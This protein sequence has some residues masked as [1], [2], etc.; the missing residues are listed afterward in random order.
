[1][2]APT[3]P[4]LPFLLGSNPVP[5]VDPADL[6]RMWERQE[7]FRVDSPD[8]HGAVVDMSGACSAGADLPAVGFRLS[9]L[10]LM[11]RIK[12]FPPGT[13]LPDALFRVL[14]TIPMTGMAPG[15]PQ[16]KLPFDPDELI[17]LLKE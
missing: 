15:A 10:S 4:R 5:A 7:E 6:R 13:K 2:E 14:A 11:R 9:M 17:R 16:Q 12:P 1:M 3:P 8:E